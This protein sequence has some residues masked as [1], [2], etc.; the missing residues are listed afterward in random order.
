MRKL[1]PQF[2]HLAS[3]LPGFG[4]DDTILNPLPVT[5]SDEIIN[6]GK[7]LV[8]CVFDSGETTLNIRAA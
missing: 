4:I 3:I 8:H 1:T 5:F 7:A 2:R 6:S